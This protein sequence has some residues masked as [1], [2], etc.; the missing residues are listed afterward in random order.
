MKPCFLILISG[1]LCVCWAQSCLT[2]G[3][4]VDCSRPV[5]SAHG[6]FLAIIQKWVSISYSKRSFQPRDWI[7]IF[8]IGRWILYHWA[9]WEALISGIFQ[10]KLIC[11]WRASPIEN[12]NIKNQTSEVEIDKKKCHVTKS[13]G[14]SQKLVDFFFLIDP[15]SSNPVQPQIVSTV[16][17][18]DALWWKSIH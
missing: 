17:N 14:L 9:T 13:W 10:S 6:I 3:D 2:L 18:I 8:C 7:H 16:E 15:T 4:P 12:Q 5:S 1:M 11:P